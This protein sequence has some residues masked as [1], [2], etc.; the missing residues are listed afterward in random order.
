[1]MRKVPDGE[2][3]PNSVPCGP[4]SDSMRA[5][6]ISRIDLL[7]DCCHRLLVQI[8]RNLAVRPV[9]RRPGMTFT[10]FMLGNALT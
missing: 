4:G 3:E 10:R 6:S 9:F 2:L 5:M 1:M 8:Y 7:R